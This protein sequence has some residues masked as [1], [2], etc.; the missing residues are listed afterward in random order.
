MIFLC[1]FPCFSTPKLIWV[2]L[3]DPTPFSLR[4]FLCSLPPSDSWVRPPFLL[5]DPPIFHLPQSLIPCPKSH[6]FMPVLCP[7]SPSIP[8]PLC[9]NPFSPLKKSD[10]FP[11]V[12]RNSSIRAEV[13]PK[14][15]PCESVIPLWLTHT[16]FV[17]SVLLF[18][19]ALW[20]PDSHSR[21]SI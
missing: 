3:L 15:P 8:P 14:L 10:T 20:S 11:F 6:P 19:V 1:F 18:L 2:S 12:Q 16:G 21:I 9:R 7:S 5:S 17:N 13:S 4:T